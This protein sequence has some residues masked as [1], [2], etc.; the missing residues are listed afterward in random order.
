MLVDQSNVRNVLLRKLSSVDFNAIASK[1]EP[2]KLVAGQVI[3]QG[4]KPIEFCYLPE[5]GL[6]T[7]VAAA[8]YTHRAEVGLVGRMGL[9]PLV[10][11]STLI[12]P[13]MTW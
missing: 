11:S 7:I 9:R 10:R 6:A 1:L 4:G 5:T 2:V 8:K 12:D 13:R 3:S